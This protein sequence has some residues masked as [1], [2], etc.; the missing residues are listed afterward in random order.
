VKQKRRKM[1]FSIFLQIASTAHT[2]K[3]QQFFFQLQQKK[4]YS[5]QVHFENAKKTLLQTY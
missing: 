5:L 1:N 2:K 3:K 4:N